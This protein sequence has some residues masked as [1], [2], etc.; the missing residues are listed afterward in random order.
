MKM[1]AIVRTEYGPPDVL[2]LEEVEKPTPKDNEVLVKVHAASVNA[3]DWHLVRGKPFLVR[4]LVGGLLKPKNKI[5]GADLAG[6]VEAVGRNVK[7]FRPGDEV[8]GCNW[9][10]FAEY[11]SVPEDALALKPVNMTFEEAAA[12]PMA[13]VTALQALRDKGHIQPGQKVLI[14]G[15]SG[16]VGTFA[17]QIAKSFGAEVTAVCSTGK[18]DTARSIGADHVIDYTKEDFTKSGPRYDLIHAAN[19][20]HPILD[21]RRALSP[22]GIYVMTGGSM[23]QIFQS[24]LLGPLISM[25]GSRKMRFATAKIYQKDLAYMKEL[26]ETGKVAPVIDRRYPLGEVPDAIRYVEEGHARGKVVITVEH[27]ARASD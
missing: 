18:L 19:G 13:A 26:L 7:Q 23:A 27:N 21:Y 10:G 9:G 15:A 2:H 4:L 24:M 22:K 5:L 25:I 6:R 14:S 17:V 11:V 12:V 20:Y 1:K 3:A 8:F 16:G